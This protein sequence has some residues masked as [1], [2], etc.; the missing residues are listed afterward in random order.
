[1]R[2]LSEKMRSA[3]LAKLVELEGFEDETALFA[4]AISDIVCPAICCNP[5]NP[6]CDYTAENGAGP[7]SRLVRGVRA[8]D[9][10][11]RARARR[12]HLMSAEAKRAK[13]RELNVRFRTTMDQR[14]GRVM[15]TAGVQALP[16]GVQVN[17]ILR[18]RTFS[19][20]NADN[21]PHGEHDF[22]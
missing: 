16:A 11:V 9:A 5:D 2:V 20:F 17:A 10:R 3:K 19:D 6:E 7:G 22:G 4:V 1:M 15:L 13:T 14:L 18:V 12:D 8:R 21:D